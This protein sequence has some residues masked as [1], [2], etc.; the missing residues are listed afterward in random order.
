[1]I[2]RV[3]TVVPAEGV[4]LERVLDATHRLPNGGLS[5]HAYGTLDAAQKRTVWGRDHRRRFALVD[6][7][8]VLASA[9]QYD[10]AAFLDQRPVRVCGIGS[11]FGDPPPR[12]TGHAE[13]LVERLLDQAARNGAVMALLFSGGSQEQLQLKGFEVVSM[14]DVELAVTESSRRGAPMT[15]IR[16]GEERDVAAIAAMGQVQ[17]SPFRFHLARD[18]DFVQYAITKKR[19]L[20]GLGEAGARQL[21]FFIAEEGITAAAY[22]VVSIVGGTWTIEEC[23]DRDPSAARVGAILQALIAREPVERR[24]TIR[25][26]LPHG[27]VPPQVTIVSAKRST[28]VLIVR[29]LGSSMI[30]PRLSGDDVL[31]WRADIF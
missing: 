6:S 26:W 9:T 13:E 18:V 29:S 21:H 7:G 19:L 15:L 27:F 3:A 20:A 22:I 14:P 17:A 8:D 10:L 31:Y 23:G 28:E 12:R 16:G 4:I 1:M 11:I 2:I 25:A 30:E 5:R 24:P